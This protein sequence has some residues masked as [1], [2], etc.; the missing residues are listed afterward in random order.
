MRLNNLSARLVVNAWLAK[1][2][3][4]PISP[5]LS[6]QEFASELRKITAKKNV[7]IPFASRADAVAYI[8][9]VAGSI[10]A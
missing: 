7:Q 6:Y 2:G 4:K 3:R 10:A 8:R 1:T 9:Y 5:E